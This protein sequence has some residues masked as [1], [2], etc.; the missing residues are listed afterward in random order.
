[1]YLVFLFTILSTSYARVT[2][3]GQDG[4]FSREQAWSCA[5]NVVDTNKDNK[6]DG[7]E[8]EAAKQKYLYFYERA[9]GWIAGPTQVS[10]VMH[11]CD[12]NG[13]HAVDATD[14]EQ[15]K[16]YC[17]PYMDPKTHWTVES[18]ALCLIKKFCDR[19]ATVLKKPVY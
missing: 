12:A 10:A 4:T 11:D 9:L 3:C 16:L 19:A 17:M 18:N 5:M 13:D 6:M 14:F 8:I 7:P 1:M 2:D 15:K